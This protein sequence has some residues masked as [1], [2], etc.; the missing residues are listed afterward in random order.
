MAKEMFQRGGI[1][2]PNNSKNLYT[3][4]DRKQKL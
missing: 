4:E 3:H 2:L 1:V